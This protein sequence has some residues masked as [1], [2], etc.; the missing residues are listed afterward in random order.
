MANSWGLSQP[1]GAADSPGSTPTLKGRRPRGRGTRAK[2]VAP[3]IPPVAAATAHKGI[4]WLHLSAIAVWLLAATVLGALALAG[5]SVPLAVVVGGAAAAAGHGLFLAVHVYL[6]SVAAKRIAAR[7][8]G[9]R[10]VPEVVALAV[11]K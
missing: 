1:D 2:A 8:A 5:R 3:S 7:A 6:A 9:D 11:Q 4:V 10:A